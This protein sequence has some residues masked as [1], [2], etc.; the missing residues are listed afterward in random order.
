M[1]VKVQI[2]PYTA[3]IADYVWTSP[4]AT[5]AEL[6][7]LMLPDGGPSGSDPNPD[8]NAARAVVATLGGKILDPGPTPAFD[9]QAIY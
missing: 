1:T 4:D 9:P 8:L 6:L 3:Q 7:N 5:L 2:G